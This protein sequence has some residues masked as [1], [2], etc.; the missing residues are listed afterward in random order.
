MNINRVMKI[1]MVGAT[2]YFGWQAWQAKKGLSA[3][4]AADAANE[5]AAK[6]IALLSVQQAQY[7]AKGMVSESLEAR[8]QIEE[9][10]AKFPKAPVYKY[11]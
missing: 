5:D 7:D 2:A 4:A 9:L 1:V 8:A 6:K 11:L 10:Q 3:Q